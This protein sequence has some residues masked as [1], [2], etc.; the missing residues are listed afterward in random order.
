M[1]V[2][3]NAQKGEN[4]DF[5]NAVTRVFEL[6]FKNLRLPWLW[7]TPIWYALGYGKEFDKHA[8][9][10]TTL[11]R[12]VGLDTPFA[13]HSPEALSPSRLRQP[14]ICFLCTIFSTPHVKKPETISLIH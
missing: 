6:F 8:K 1:G 14:G 12:K 13:F 7:I 2:Q 4:Q 3:I 9:I 5:Y 11:V 10:I